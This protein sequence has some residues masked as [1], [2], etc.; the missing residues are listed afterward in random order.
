MRK[1]ANSMRCSRSAFTLTELIVVI[2]I[3]GLIVGMATLSLLGLVGRKTFKADVH[4]FVSAMQMAAAA[5]AQ[6]DRRYEII[7]DIGE[8]AYLLREISTADVFAIYEEEIIIDNYFGPNCMVAYVEFDDGKWT[9]E[10]EAKFRAG[11][12]GWQYGGKI[13]LL[14]NDEQP[15][16][17]VI[18]RL[19]RMI[20]AKEGDLEILAPRSVEDVVF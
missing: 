14:D 7:I 9:N 6:G 8:Q 11:H 12:S 13:V 18:N 20:V 4:E 1:L 2:V 5:A 19:N 10:G 15:Y 16:T 17:V 3:I